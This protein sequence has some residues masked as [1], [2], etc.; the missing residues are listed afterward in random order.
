MIGWFVLASCISPVFWQLSRARQAFGVPV[1]C[2]AESSFGQTTLSVSRLALISHGFQF[3][4]V[5][6]SIVKNQQTLH[7]GFALLVAQLG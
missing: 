3:E 4:G 5:A 1:K 6:E 2:L 7:Q